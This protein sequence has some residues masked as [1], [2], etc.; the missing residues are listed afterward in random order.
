MPIKVHLDFIILVYCTT[1]HWKRKFQV[2]LTHKFQGSKHFRLLWEKGINVTFASPIEFGN[3][4]PLCLPAPCAEPSLAITGIGSKSILCCQAHP[5]TVEEAYSFKIWQRESTKEGGQVGGSGKMGRI[6]NWISL[7]LQPCQ[8]QRHLGK[9]VLSWD[10]E[11]ERVAFCPSWGRDL[12]AQGQPRRKG[13][14]TWQC[15]FSVP[16]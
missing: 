2:D 12:Q 13:V 1:Q 11:E 4:D 10:L 3:R 8:F 7:K 9:E 16:Q 6:C 5:I 15:D 14:V